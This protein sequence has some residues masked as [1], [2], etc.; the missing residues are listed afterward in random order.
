MMAFLENKKTDLRYFKSCID[1]YDQTDLRN[2]GLVVKLFYVL[3]AGTY[4]RRINVIISL[5]LLQRHRR[6]TL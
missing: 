2:S 5:R 1:L 6:C 4:N 3:S